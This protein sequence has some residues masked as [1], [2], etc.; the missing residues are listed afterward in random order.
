[1]SE[2]KKEISQE[3]VESYIR[4]ILK[5]LEKAGKNCLSKK[6]LEAKCKINQGSPASFNAAIC[7]GHAPCWKCS[8]L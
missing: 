4:K 5:A 2:K 7:H 1:M 8:S 6:E 3:L